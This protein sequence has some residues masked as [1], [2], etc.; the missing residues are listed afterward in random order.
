MLKKLDKMDKI[1]II[2]SLILVIGIGFSVRKSTEGILFDYPIMDGIHSNITSVGTLIMKFLSFIGSKY[3]YGVLGLGL[4]VFYMKEND[5]YAARLVF[6][7]IVGAYILNAVIKLLVLRTRPVDYM[8][9]QKTSP[10]FP[11]GHSMVSMS[12]YTTMSYILLRRT[13]DEKKKIIGSII[14]VIISVGIAYSRLYL[15]VHWPTDVFVGGVLGFTY[16]RVSRKLVR[17]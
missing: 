11:S 2:I 4:V 13:E 15:G 16:S 14:A 7:S 6:A 8:L 5:R 10:S 9:V 12:F 3:F 1:L 17:P